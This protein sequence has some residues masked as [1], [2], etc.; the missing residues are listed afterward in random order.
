MLTLT[1]L[2][3]TF[4]FDCEDHER[5]RLIEAATML[6][7]KLDQ[8]P[9]MKEKNKILMTALNLCFD[10]LKLKDDTVQY[11]LR[12]EDQLDTVMNQVANEKPSETATE[13]TQH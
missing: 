8:L 2:D 13:D 12:L 9:N 3:S 6:E 11:S 7:D 5:E 10:Y 4:E 1:L